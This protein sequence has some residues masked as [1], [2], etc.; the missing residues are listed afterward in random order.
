MDSDQNDP[1]LDE[2]GAPDTELSREP[3]GFEFI[4]AEEELTQET[5]YATIERVLQK[6][7]TARA[8]G[9]ELRE[10]YLLVLYNRDGLLSH[11]SPTSPTDVPLNVLRMAQMIAEHGSVLIE[12]LALILSIARQICK[13]ATEDK[14]RSNGNPRT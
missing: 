9:A 13:G 2:A 10:F 3:D 4:G 14:S 12:R 11:M 6:I 5:R 1:R 7:H 8:A